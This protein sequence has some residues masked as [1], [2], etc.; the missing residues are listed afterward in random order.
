MTTRI[1]HRGCGAALLA[2]ALSGCLSLEESTPS[3]FVT[4]SLVVAAA[5]DMHTIRISWAP[6]PD[7]DLGGYVVERRTS[8]TGGFATVADVGRSPSPLYLDQGLTAGTFYGYRVRAVTQLGG[9]SSPSTVAGAR[10][11]DEPGIVVAVSTLAESPDFLDPDGYTVTLAGPDTIVAPVLPSGQRTFSPLTPGTWTAELSGLAPNCGAGDGLTQPI[12]VTDVGLAT[13]PVAAFSILCVNPTAGTLLVEVLVGGDDDNP[14]ALT[15]ELTGVTVDG[16]VTRTTQVPP[17]GG[18]AVFGDLPA[19]D[20]QVDLGGVGTRC[21]VAGGT[22]RSAGLTALAI[23]TVAYVVTCLAAEEEPDPTRPYVLRNRWATSPAPA[24]TVARLDVSYDLRD[25]P[26]GTLLGALQAELQYNE[27]VVR[28][29]SARAGDLG[30]PTIN[31]GQPGRVIYLLIS[32]A[33]RGD[34]MKV[35]SFFFTVVGT[36]G[37]TVTTRTTLSTAVTIDEIDL[38]PLSRASEGTLTVGAGS[39]NAPPVA[40][41]NGPYSGV[42][43]VPVILT[44]AGSTDPDG[45]LTAYQWSFSGGGTATGVTAGRTFGA[46]GT[47][48]ATLTVTDDDGATDTD[49]ATITIGAG[50]GNLPPVAQVNGPYSGS[51][52][53]PIAFTAAGSS[54]PDGSL[55][56]YAWSFTDGTTATGAA[57]LK[58]FAAAGTYQATLTVT[59]NGGLTG[60]ATTSVTVATAG[61][62]PTPFV[63]QGS[64]GAVNAAD[65]TVALTITLDLSTDIPETPGA[66]QLQSWVVDSMRWDPALLTYL[67]FN[68]GAGG[69]GSV[70]PTFALTQGRLSFSGGQ[71]SGANNS[72]LVTIAI[73]RFKL[74]G[75]GGSAALVRA[76]PGAILGTAATGSFSYRSRTEVVDPTLILP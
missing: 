32:P 35:V 23:D 48:I 62:D 75:A 30:A 68:F 54:D 60:T 36:A 34:S 42:V 18:T 43:G 14:T 29:D 44:A 16:A 72:G 59:D 27:S 64:F 50:G 41:A 19:G 71:G 37:Q 11:A 49:Q 8:L 45:T 61:S 12:E 38:L 76:F 25:A 40:E 7:P 47:Y 74:I 65:S 51:A 15:V 4:P 20:Y 3:A 66:E 73:I 39:V 69:S 70:N 6:V 56:G 52:G 67:S 13:R 31:A 10:T 57:P 9:A 26:D 17:D 55:T 2:L 24:G 63:W 1:R 22:V 21:S 53:S 58:T 5:L 33:G 28:Y 46:A